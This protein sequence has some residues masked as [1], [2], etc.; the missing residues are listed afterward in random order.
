MNVEDIASKVSVIIG[1]EILLRPGR[2]SGGLWGTSSPRSW[3]FF[4]DRH[5]LC[6]L[7]YMC[8]SNESV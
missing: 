6:G 2:G 1:M 5:P 4:C 7:F 3:S 8:R